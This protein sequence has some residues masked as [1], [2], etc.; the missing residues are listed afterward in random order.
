MDRQPLNV[1]EGVAL[2]SWGLAA[3]AGGIGGGLA[4]GVA[5]TVLGLAGPPWLWILAY[6]VVRRLAPAMEG[7]GPSHGRR[8]RLGMVVLAA[9]VLRL[10]GRAATEAFTSAG[11]ATAR[12]GGG[13]GGIAAGAEGAALERAVDLAGL[14]TWPH[15]L[16]WPVALAVLLVLYQAWRRDAGLRGA[17]TALLVAMPAVMGGPFLTDPVVAEG[18]AAAYWLVFGL[19]NGR[20]GAVRLGP[21][22]ALS[23]PGWG[24]RDRTRGFDP[25]RVRIVISGFYGAGNAGDE[26]ILASL[27]AGLRARGYR[28]ITVFSIRPD[29]TSRQHGVASVYRGWRRQL[30]TKVRTL[31]RTHVFIS[32]GG[33]LLQDATPTFLFRGPVPYYLL[34]ATLARLL[35]CWVLFLGQGVG[36]L[37]GRWVRFLTRLLANHADAITVRDAGSLGLLAEVGVTRP[38]RWLAADFVFAAP[39]PDPQRAAAVA[40]REG[41][42]PGGRW[43][44]VS[45]RSWPGSERFFPELA[46]FL[47]HVL[48]RDA[49]LRVVLVPMEG[50]M[51]HAAA[52]QLVAYMSQG[53]SGVGRPDGRERVASARQRV[54][55]LQA[56]YEAADLE[57]FVA[58]AWLAVGM[59]LHFLLFAARA[60]VPVLALAYDPKVGAAMDRLGMSRFV[61]RLDDVRVD[62]L[63]A[64]YQELVAR[65][66]EISRSLRQAAVELAPLA[67]ASLELVDAAA[68]R[69]LARPRPVPGGSTLARSRPG[70]EGEW[71]QEGGWCC[72]AGLAAAGCD[73][74]TR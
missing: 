30:W 69:A 49:D 1:V 28:D 43:L 62:R 67:A 37:R 53:T 60:G 21:P 27:L 52:E 72:A 45:V 74:E 22:S 6:A 36:P 51:D 44:A 65:H 66:D 29:W 59:R 32:G 9:I 54:H 12:L 7:S 33:G 48:A 3:L 11:A 56:D 70:D 55:I 16:P 71:R 64:A 8:I 10:A 2:V 50:A 58:R 4:G 15:T 24:R 39:P 19:F 18:A 31:A 35:G 40:A 47:E 63:L 38:P 34:I 46:A 17:A 41:L 42:D 73:A 26:A 13:A 68:A 25:A 20:Y 61:L 14:L 57:A 23:G 5:D